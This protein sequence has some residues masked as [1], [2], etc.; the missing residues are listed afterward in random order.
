MKPYTPSPYVS[1]LLQRYSILRR[2]GL[3][4]QH[5]PSSKIFALPGIGSK[6]EN[7]DGLHIG[8][9]LSFRA[10]WLELFLWELYLIMCIVIRAFVFVVKTTGRCWADR[11]CGSDLA[12]CLHVLAKSLGLLHSASRQKRVRIIKTLGL[13]EEHR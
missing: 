7:F 3:V 12:T 10:C 11:M 13:T 5:P 8:K 4:K 6:V 1:D 9:L 2:N